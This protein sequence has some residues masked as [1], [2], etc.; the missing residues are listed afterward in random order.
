M[1]DDEI[2]AAAYQPWHPMTDPQDLKTLGKL[3]EELGECQ[4]AAMRCLVQGIDEKEP[5]TGKVNRHWLED[6]IADVAV[7]MTLVIERFGL[8]EARINKRAEAKEP[9]LRAWHDGA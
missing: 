4:A 3:G 1:N 5:K 9:L 7:N 2:P 8:D 6:E